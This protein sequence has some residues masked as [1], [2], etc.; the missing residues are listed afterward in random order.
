LVQYEELTLPISD[1]TEVRGAG[2]N[3][4]VV[5]GDGKAVIFSVNAKATLSGLT[6]T[7]GAGAIQS[8]AD[9]TLRGVAV[10]DN[11]REAAGG[12]IQSNGPLTIDSSF[13]GFNRTNGS[14]GG[15][16]QAN[17]SVTLLNSTVA[18]NS[19]KGNGGINGNGAVAA[20]N[21]TVVFNSSEES[22]VGVKGSPLT[23]RNSIVAGNENS[24]GTFNCFSVTEF[25]SLGGNVSDDA[26]CGT[27]A[28]DRP[29]VNPL[30]GTLALH[31][32]T[33]RLYDLL[34]GSPAID[35]AS[36]CPPLDQRGA[37]RPQ[38]AACDSGSYEATPPP[39]VTPSSSNSRFFMRVGRK[40]RLRDYAIWVRLKCPRSTVSPPCRGRAYVTNPPL[41]FEGSGPR[42][43]QLRPL[44]GK[45]SIRPGE[46]EA[47]ALRRPFGRT[48]RLPEKPGKWRVTLRVFANDG[49]GEKW[50]FQKRRMPLIAR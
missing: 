35:A 22:G 10:E 40:L 50:N 46:V 34:P 33:T 18:W 8:N 44:W 13:I 23:V 32:G 47:V 27:G 38:G 29:N 42:T 30:L 1:E 49:A 20:T 17:S 39:L 45:F 3:M 43:M 36:G 31:G 14:S 9:L 37:A 24:T 7:G 19:S 21:S 6:M 5:E 48:S 16:I 2:A 4:T 26:T 15:A 25:V 41:V 12:G 11:E 28:T